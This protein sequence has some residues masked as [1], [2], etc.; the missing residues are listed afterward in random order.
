MPDYADTE[1]VRIHAWE[2][3]QDELLVE[4]GDG[5]LPGAIGGYET[6]AHNLPDEDPLRAVT[7]YWLAHARWNA[8]DVDGA[9]E[10]LHDC[11]RRPG[12]ARD[13]CLRL[14]GDL[15]LEES[16]VRS[17]PVLWRF[18]S[19][20]H[21]VMRLGIDDRGA[22]RIDADAPGGD[23]ALLWTMI[24]D[25][26]HPDEIVVGFRDPSPDPRGVRFEARGEVT[27]ARVRILAVDA[28]GREWSPEGTLP[29]PK[30]RWT[31]IDISLA[32]LIGAAPAAGPFPDADIDRV[33]IVDATPPGQGTGEH[34][35]WLDDFEVY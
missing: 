24:A 20:G 7:L 10:A 13:L 1:E 15:E 32:D 31:T 8:G 4:A 6:L 25:L 3:L 9:R 23:P 34:G 21:G 16:S 33:R 17:V 22:L 35:I 19:A 11:I 26:R 27:D 2:R 18:D 14:L 28:R 5:D 29:V 12:N 30:D